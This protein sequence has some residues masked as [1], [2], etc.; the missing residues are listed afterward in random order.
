MAANDIYFDNAATTRPSPDVCETVCQA[1]RERY[2]NP[3]SLHAR[4]YEAERVVGE[5]RGDVARAMG[6]DAGRVF[7]TAGGTEANNMAIAGVC[8][9]APRGGANRAV[10][11]RAEHPSVLEPYKAAERNG[12]RV[13]YVKVDSG[14]IIDLE[15]LEAALDGGAALITLTCVNNET[16]AIQ[17]IAEAA[18]LRDGKCPDALLHLD[19]AQS[20]AKLPLNP[21]KCGLDI[22]TA[23]A[24]KI[25]GPKGAGAIWLSE[26]VRLNPLMLGGGQEGGLR[27]GTE[28]VPA[29]AGFG[30]A[31]RE[32]AG[33]QNEDYEHARNLKRLMLSEISRLGVECARV[34]ENSPCSP[35]ILTL[36]FPGLLSEPLI[37]HLSREG[38]YASSGSACSSRRR[39]KSG[40]HVL[41]AMGLRR[42][43]I[44]GAV[45]FSFSRYNTP[46][47]VTAAVEIL[48][49]VTSE[50]A[51][52]GRRQ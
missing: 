47:E 25:H 21:V 12:W 16:G 6:T 7:F 44:E 32:A 9:H 15:A 46:A 51:R 35:Y 49:N 50:I 3:S 36:S 37:N 11:T 13:E 41:A 1:M 52:G 42:D 19:C 27:P 34:S 23:S 45:R 5:A 40:S 18:A 31:A 33:R 14:G 4:G 8:G 2:G 29:I 39:A 20:F 17:P 10:T 48:K 22:V 28:N 30:T 43:I 24:H 38:V 26:R